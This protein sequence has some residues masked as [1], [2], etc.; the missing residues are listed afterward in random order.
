M[1]VFML[2]HRP[3]LTFEERVDRP[4]GEWSETG[5]LTKGDFQAEEGDAHKHQADDVGDQEGTC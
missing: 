1:V 5:E 2:C 4:Y 3:G